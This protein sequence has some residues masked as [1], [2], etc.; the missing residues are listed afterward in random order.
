M[1]ITRNQVSNLILLLLIAILLFTPVG[2]Y[3]R[4]WVN[5]LFSFSPGVT[6]VEDRTVLKHYD[7]E[8]RTLEGQPF[9]LSE[10]KGKVIVLNFWATWCPPCLAEMPALQRLYDSYRNEVVFIFVSQE[11]PGVLREFMKEK[12][13]EFPVYNPWNAPP[14][15]LTSESIPMTYVIGKKGALVISKN[16]AADWNSEKVR[17][18][19]DGLLAEQLENRK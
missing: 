9:N 16:G 7:W 17:T 8:L 11:Q 1:K 19:I 12:G 4:I 18:V 10:A 2:K 15:A 5:R 3:A 6:A 14:K 13:Y